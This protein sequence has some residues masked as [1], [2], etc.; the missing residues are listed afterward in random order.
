MREKETSETGQHRDLMGT[1]EGPRLGGVGSHVP[2]AAE[3]RVVLSW[4]DWKRGRVYRKVESPMN[5]GS[6]ILTP[7]WKIVL[8]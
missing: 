4:T 1:L 5:Q 7:E 6:W 2:V 8:S 3:N